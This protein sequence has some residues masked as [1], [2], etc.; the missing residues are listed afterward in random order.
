MQPRGW[1]IESIG[2][3]WEAFSE[4]RDVLGE[5]AGLENADGQLARD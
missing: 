1:A 2:V 5:S 4:H 3:S